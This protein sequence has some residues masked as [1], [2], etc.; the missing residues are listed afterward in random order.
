MPIILNIK[1]FE[2]VELFVWEIIEDETDFII[3]LPNIEFLDGIKNL[4]LRK[5]KL[6]VRI[7][8]EQLNYKSEISYST[9]GK[10]YLKDKNIGISHS[11]EF[12]SVILSSKYNVSVDIETKNK[13]TWELRHKFL[14]KF[15]LDKIE[16]SLHSCLAWSAKECYVKLYDSPKTEFK[17]LSTELLPNNKI[18]ITDFTGKLDLYNYTITENYILVWAIEAYS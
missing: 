6:A 8:L 14:N 1:P 3:N 13:K 11:S 10:P 18:K 12:V 17:S 4:N 5:Q 16:T 2:D 7:L 9:N 15:E